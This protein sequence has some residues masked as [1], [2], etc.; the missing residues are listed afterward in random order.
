MQRSHIDFNCLA[1]QALYGSEEDVETV[2]NSLRTVAARVAETGPMDLI[3]SKNNKG[4]YELRTDDGNVISMLSKK[5]TDSLFAI[6]K[7]L[8]NDS[9]GL[10]PPRT[11]KGIKLMDFCT[12]VVGEDASICH[13]LHSPWDDQGII[14]APRIIG[15]PWVNFN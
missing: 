12:M 9:P 14:L 4:L 2:Q 7:R 3:A 8:N 5:V 15:Y 10:Y 13:M 1:G 11:F 6:G